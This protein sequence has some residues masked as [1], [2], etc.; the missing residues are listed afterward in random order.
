MSFYS[1]DDSSMSQANSAA[2]S[3]S[4]NLTTT[5]LSLKEVKK[6]AREIK[7]PILPFFRTQAV[8]HSNST[9]PTPLDDPQLLVRSES[10][11]LL[12]SSIFTNK[13]S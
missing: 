11:P 7:K 6:I 12:T 13:S 5:N 1:P 10:A 2:S 9:P 4:N 3:V 8:S